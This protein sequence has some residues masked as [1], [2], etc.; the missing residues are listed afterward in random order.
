MSDDKT[1]TLQLTAREV[2]RLEVCLDDKIR[3]YRAM[4]ADVDGWKD[5]PSLRAAAHAATAAY[6]DKLLAL[7]AKLEAAR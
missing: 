1:L 2:A 6:L 5:D 7:L 4:L 3:E